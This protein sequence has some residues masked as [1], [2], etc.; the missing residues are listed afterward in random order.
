[1]RMIS[2][3]GNTENVQ[4][5]QVQ[6]KSVA[7]GSLIKSNGNIISVTQEAEETNLT[8]KLWSYASNGWILWGGDLWIKRPLEDPGNQMWESFICLNTNQV[9]MCKINVGK[10]VKGYQ[11]DLRWAEDSGKI[12]QLSAD[13]DLLHRVLIYIRIF[14]DTHMPK[15]TQYGHSPSCYFLSAGFK[16]QTSEISHS[17]GISLSSL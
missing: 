4:Y 3:T 5:I 2:H 1:M 10:R 8:L 16:I 11:A 14:T 17:G 7:H 15:H 13:G 12:P 9:H 6:N